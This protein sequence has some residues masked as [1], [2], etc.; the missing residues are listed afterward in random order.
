VGRRSSIPI[1]LET[2][3]KFGRNPT[4]LSFFVVC[5]YVLMILPMAASRDFD[6]SVFV[7]AGDKY[8][9]HAK[10]AAPLRIAIQSGGYDGQFFY[11]LARRPLS[12][13]PTF[14]GVRF[15]N[16]AKRMQRIIYPALA[17]LASFG[18]ATLTPASLV[19]VNLAGLGIAAAAAA[20]LAR[21][22]QLAWW[23]PYA[24]TGWPGFL[25]ALTHDT[26]EIVAGALC[27]VALAC[28]LS[29]RLTAY[30]ATVALATLC[31]ETTIPIFLGPLIYEGWAAAVSP[32]SLRLRRAALC[33]LAFVPFGIWHEVIGALWNATAQPLSGSPDLGWP[34]VG[35]VKM[36]W[37][38]IFD[39]F[40]GEAGAA[41]T[42][43][44]RGF[45]VATTIGLIGF[46][47][48]T[49]TQLR[50]VVGV[51]GVTGLAIG[52]MLILVLMSLM[53]ATGPWVG[54]QAY[55]RAFT[56][57][58]IV[59]CLLLALSPAE[60]PMCN[61]ALLS[62]VFAVVNIFIWKICFSVLPT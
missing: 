14:E 16:S 39:G 21:R 54:P 44:H 2:I 41:A 30:C 7:I 57:C 52:W 18:Q 26:A 37:G 35:V 10:L 17:W 19:L 49:G 1:N 38:Q 32:T 36:L 51:P 24:V 55:F 34:M 61:T 3:E 62:T 25:V 23:F 5:F 15:D 27:L 45:V 12:V 6:L 46:C 56:E 29:D 13:E 8:V 9:D 40:D 33:A 60:P 11:R 58:W 59:G 43:V 20:W 47:V 48:L 28:Y 50:R 22:L 53:T 4:G 42:F 31:R